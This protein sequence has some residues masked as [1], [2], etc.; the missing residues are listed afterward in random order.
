MRHESTGKF[1][2]LHERW[3]IAETAGDR[4]WVINDEL[5]FLAK[6]AAACTLLRGAERG[7]GEAEVAA[8]ENGFEELE[9]LLNGGIVV[10]AKEGERSL[11]SLV[12][13]KYRL[14]LNA[15]RE[16]L[17]A[18]VRSAV[19]RE[20]WAGA[21]SLSLLEIGIPQVET[22]A[23]WLLVAED[24]L[25]D[26]V[27]DRLAE[28]QEARAAALVIA[29]WG[30]AS[31]IG[32]WICAEAGAC[33]ECFQ[34]RVRENRW[35]EASLRRRGKFVA[36]SGGMTT[37][38]S[39]ALAFRLAAVR[40]ERAL[41][42]GE[43]EMR[44]EVEEWDA[45]RGQLRRHR[46]DW[47]ADCARCQRLERQG[48][49]E[50]RGNV[51][52]LTGYL[53]NGEDLTPKKDWPVQIYGLQYIVPLAAGAEGASIAP[54]WATGRGFNRKEAKRKAIFEGIERR[55]SFWHGDEKVLRSTARDLGTAAILPAEMF[56]VEG[57]K[58]PFDVLELMDWVRV[59]NLLGEQRWI[60]ASLCYFGYPRRET[61]SVGAHSNGC[62]L[63]RTPEDA[64][65]RA[66]LELIE[67][68]AVL[69]WWRN[70]VTLPCLRV[71]GKAAEMLAFVRDAG[72]ELLLLDA[73]LDWEVPVCLAV[74]MTQRSAYVAAAASFDGNDAVVKAC[75][76]LFQ[77]FAVRGFAEVNPD[78]RPTWNLVDGERTIKD[79]YGVA[80]E[81]TDRLRWLHQ[82]AGKLGCGLWFADLTRPDLG[83]PVARAVGAGMGGQR[84][85]K[86]P[87]TLGWLHRERSE[88][89]WNQRPLPF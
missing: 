19:E 65:A 49:R 41:V 68:E 36:A 26:W 21:V 15:Y 56:L 53:R 44:S 71:D 54:N 27:S 32:P 70:E 75:T 48:V 50:R 78:V 13:D 35:I 2:W 29:P 73:T 8:V 61:W 39:A 28:A 18:G 86:V 43:A 24:W 42:L 25:S 57:L 30:E 62:A 89:E 10:E 6:G 34:R 46:V 82:R 87:V 17:A 80:V 76:E 47:L 83:W 16:R 66:V 5:L 74:V 1:W 52:A 4:C 72:A 60:P 11:A 33:V 20:A 31:L 81:Q 59:E 14:T 64:R 55:S 58:A 79:G 84:L 37:T 7:I 23:I 77:T 67:R 3:R 85:R 40:L 12:R 69:A 63:G 22:S 88:A 38:A 9:S 51:S 45:T